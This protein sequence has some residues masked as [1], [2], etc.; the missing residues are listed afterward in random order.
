MT[1]IVGVSAPQAGLRVKI[2][3]WSTRRQIGRPTGRETAHVIES[4]QIRNP[5]YQ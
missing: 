1:R 2:A 4:L 3:Y 5:G